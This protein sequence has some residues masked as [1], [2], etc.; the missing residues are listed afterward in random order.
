MNVSN[1]CA[2]GSV[3]E[4]RQRAAERQDVGLVEAAQCRM[5]LAR[6]GRLAGDVRAVHTGAE[7]GREAQVAFAL[8]RMPSAFASIRCARHDSPGGVRRTN[9]PARNRDGHRPIRCTGC[10]GRWRGGRRPARRNGARS[11]TCAS[12]IAP[13][14]G[15]TSS[16]SC[17]GRVAL[18]VVCVDHEIWDARAHERLRDGRAAGG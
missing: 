2:D 13:R 1:T 11:A 8:S 7:L 9:P 5:A 12:V 10:S 18:D 16:R 4:R 15:R 17:C 3:L 14:L 6:G